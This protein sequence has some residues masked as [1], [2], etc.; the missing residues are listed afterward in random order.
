MSRTIKTTPWKHLAS[1]DLAHL[2]TPVHDHRF[3][4]CDLPGSPLLETSSRCTWEPSAS[5]LFGPN[6]LTPVP[7]ESL[8]TLPSQSRT[9]RHE[10]HRES[11]LIERASLIGVDPDEL[12]EVL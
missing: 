2:A 4:D 8:P 10:L 7:E 5:A 12:D 11:H 9:L 6:H 3:G 1:S